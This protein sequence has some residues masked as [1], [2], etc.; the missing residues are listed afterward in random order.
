MLVDTLLSDSRRLIHR[1]HNKSGQGPR[2]NGIY[3]L[4]GYMRNLLHFIPNKKLRQRPQV[5]NDLSDSR[6]AAFTRNVGR[7]SNP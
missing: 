5:L 7:P 1:C 6:N 3:V 2:A 4:S